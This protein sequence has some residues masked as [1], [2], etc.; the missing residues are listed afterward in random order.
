MNLDDITIQ[1]FKN[2]FFRDFPY[3]NIWEATKTYNIG[4]VV[5]YS[6]TN[7]FYKCKTN[8]T[9][10]IPTTVLNWDLESDDIFN[11][12]LDADIT[13]AQAEAKML[14]NMSLFGTDA[15]IILAFNYLTAHFLAI[16]IRRSSEG[17]NSKGDYLTNSQSVGSVS[18][19]KSIPSSISDNPYLNI[20]ITTGYGQKYIGLVM[21]R[22]IGRMSV[23]AG[24]TNA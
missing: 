4:N 23:V 2:Q 5:Y 24:G 15:E 21:P 1:D 10:S 17:I 20:F 9:I 6:V 3:L 12:V 22:L 11:Y 18:E 13:K 16:D 19:S 14:F 8:G 7:L